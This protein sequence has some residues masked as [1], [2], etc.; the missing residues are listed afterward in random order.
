MKIFFE[1]K[2]RPALQVG[3]TIHLFIDACKVTGFAGIRKS[4]TLPKWLA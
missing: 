2:V 4:M 3:L 1:V